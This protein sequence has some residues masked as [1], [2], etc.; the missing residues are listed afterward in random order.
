MCCSLCLSG[1]CSD[2]PSASLKAAQRMARRPC[3]PICWADSSARHTRFRSWSA[4]VP[5]G[6]RDEAPPFRRRDGGKHQEKERRKHRQPKETAAPLKRLK[7]GSCCC[8]P[9]LEWWTTMASTP[10]VGRRGRGGGSP[11]SCRYRRLDPCG[12]AALCVLL[13]ARCAA[14]CSLRRP[15]Y[16]ASVSFAAQFAVQFNYLGFTR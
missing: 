7:G 11:H 6:E 4:H 15:P 14:L 3:P 1:R 12:S 10:N 2:L 16:K 9:P 5:H 13:V 8:S